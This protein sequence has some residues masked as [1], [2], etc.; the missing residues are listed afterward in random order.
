MR[1][2]PVIFDASRPRHRQRGHPQDNA[3]VRVPLEVHE[4]LKAHP[5]G[6]TPGYWRALDIFKDSTDAH[7]R[8]E[9]NELIALA[10]DEGLFEGQAMGALSVAMLQLL[11]DKPEVARPALAKAIERIRSEQKKGGKR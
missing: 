1:S 9:W 6:K 5:G 11:R 2:A 7:R 3:G 10:N 8:D 4:E